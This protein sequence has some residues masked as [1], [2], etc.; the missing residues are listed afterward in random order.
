MSIAWSIWVVD[1]RSRSIA[2]STCLEEGV[3]ERV[4][5]LDEARFLVLEVLVEGAP[6]GVRVADDVGDLRL[7][8][9]FLADRGGEAL[10]QP[11][12][13]GGEGVVARGL[14]GVASVFG[15]GRHPP[16]LPAGARPQR[17]SISLGKWPNSAR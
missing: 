13:L 2:R 12:V 3:G 14:L 6:R 17:R 16:T 4:H 11:R 5:Q 1:R 10:H 15:V 7:R 8:Q 9:P